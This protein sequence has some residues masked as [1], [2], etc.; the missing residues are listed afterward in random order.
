MKII[1]DL[2]TNG[3]PEKKGNDFYNPSDTL[4]YENSRIVQIGYIMIDN[5][6]EIIARKSF[7]VKPTFEITNSN[8]HGITKETALKYGLDI[9]DILRILEHDFKNCNLFISHNIPFDKNV[10]LSEIYRINKFS[11]LLICLI[12]TSTFCTMENGRKKF[13]LQ[14]FPKLIELFKLCYPN[15]KWI[16]IHDALDDCEKC[17][18]CYKKIS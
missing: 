6:N 11:S 5:S 18:K 2:E 14:K 17:L 7:L 16:Q 1:L 12:T 15:E 4:K 13:T 10:L 8:I 9:E 3:L